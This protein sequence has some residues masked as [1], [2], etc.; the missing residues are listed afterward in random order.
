[1]HNASIEHATY[2]GYICVYGT[3]KGAESLHWRLSFI[4]CR[5]ITDT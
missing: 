3:D 4:L 5:K 2:R 1:M